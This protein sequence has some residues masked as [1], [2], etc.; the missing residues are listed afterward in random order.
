MA[1][2]PF[3][4]VLAALGC[5][6]NVES[7]RETIAI[8]AIMSRTG[9]LGAEGQENLQALH[10][11][12]GEI[13]AAGGVLGKNLKLVIRDDR[14]TL[15]GAVG[16]AQ[17]MVALQVPAVVGALASGSSLAAG[18]I[19]SAAGIVQV[20]PSSTSPLI[21]TSHLTTTPLLFRT[22]SSDAQQ[23]KLLAERAR[24]RAFQKAAVLHMP[25]VYGQ[26]LAEVFSAEFT[27]RGGQVTNVVMYAEHQK[28]YVETL[29]RILD[30]NPQ[31]LLVI[32][33]VDDVAQVV[34]DYNT[35]FTAK[36][37]FFY[38]TDSVEVPA[39]VTI[40]GGPGS[41]SFQ[42]EG[43]GPGSPQSPEY[44]RY[45]QAFKRSYNTESNPGAYPHNAYDALHLIA[46]AIEANRSPAGLVAALP[47]VSSGGAKFGPGQW[48]ELSAAIRAGLDVDYQGASG[49]VDLDVHGDV[50]APYD[51]WRI[52]GSGQI[53]IIE[54]SVTP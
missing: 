25:G 26:G 30:S 29:G 16:A 8:G 44:E 34:R 51:I 50:V 53:Q 49:S 17:A 9:S 48:Q 38:F 5:Y 7:G 1:R 41:F 24:Q 54:R 39:F 12:L 14:S 6:S 10:L 3:F 40:A 15:P 22:C 18:A 46:A 33:Y 32:G 43:T 21:T 36:Q 11:A 47:G 37:A 45:R 42:H 4:M 31:A 28:S 19:T 2:T 20:T 52:D 27:A 13:N 35:N 23:G